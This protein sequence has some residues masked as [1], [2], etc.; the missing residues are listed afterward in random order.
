MEARANEHH[1]VLYR[2]S[3]DLFPSFCCLDFCV[4]SSRNRR[5]DVA[6]RSQWKRWW[7]RWHIHSQVLGPLPDTDWHSRQ[8]L[9]LDRVVWTWYQPAVFSVRSAGQCTQTW[10]H[11]VRSKAPVKI[12]AKGSFVHRLCIFSV[13]EALIASL[14]DLDSGYSDIDNRI[15]SSKPIYVGNTQKISSTGSFLN[16]LFNV[17]V[18]VCLWNRL[19]TLLLHL[20][21]DQP[22]PPLSCWMKDSFIQNNTWREAISLR[23]HRLQTRGGRRIWFNGRLSYWDGRKKRKRGLSVSPSGSFNIT[24]GQ[25]RKQMHWFKFISKEKKAKPR[26]SI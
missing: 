19:P 25:L 17:R 18:C 2:Q 6:V 24:D 22:W 20:T 14:P 9:Q 7:W 8:R 3:C 16:H 26:N 11:P 5:G 21:S 1:S 23:V 4:G 10:H 13:S 12:S 15:Q